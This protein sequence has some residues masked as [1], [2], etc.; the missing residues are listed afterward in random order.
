[1]TCKPFI[2]AIN[3]AT[4]NIDAGGSVDFDTN[5]VSGLGIFHVDGTPSFMIGRPG[6]YK[7]TV[8]A[9]VT[10]ATATDNVEWQI[11][12][13]GVPIATGNFT[14]VADISIHEHLQSAVKVLHS[15]RVIDNKAN[16]VVRFNNAVTVD[17]PTIIISL[18]KYL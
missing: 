4:Q 9:D 10:V 5:L 15:C 6:I 8:D 3:T 12:N 18:E 16:I 1:M 17:N 2:Y 11:L 7:I 13:N 14:G